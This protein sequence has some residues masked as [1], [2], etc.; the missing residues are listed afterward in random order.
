MPRLARLDAAGALHHVLVRGIE[1]GAIF[2]DRK[3]R[4]DFLLRLSRLVESESLQV[5]AWALMTNHVHLLIRTCRRSLSSSMRSLLSGYATAFNR[6]HRRAG[7]LFQNRFKSIVCE[8][9]PYFL[10]LIRYI[11]LNPVRA[12]IVSSLE[13]LERYPYSGHAAIVGS[14]SRPWQEVG[15]VLG[16]FGDRRRDAVRRYR[17]FVAEGLAKGESEDLEGGG[18]VRG[19]DGWMAVGSL[20][21]GRESFRA[22]ERV[23]G[24]SKFVDRLMSEVAAADARSS[25]VSLEELVA[26]VADVH[27]LSA[28]GLRSGSRNRRHVA[29]RAELSWIWTE[30]L[31]RSGRALAAELGVTAPAIYAGA[32]RHAATGVGAREEVAR[33]CRRRQGAGGPSHRVSDAAAAYGSKV[34]CGGGQAE[35]TI[36]ELRSLIRRVCRDREVTQAAVLGGGR[37]RS[38]V[39]ARGEICW[40]W[41]QRMGGSG[42]H[43]A[44]VLGLTAAAVYAASRR[45]ESRWSG[46]E[47]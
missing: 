38:V 15:E 28:D 18:L 11:H 26:I 40:E 46:V 13:G 24:S 14:L 35:R 6:R 39:E 10:E 31:G 21:R 22:D 29:A 37:G 23:L 44:R 4:E 8:E 30:Y 9:E 45:F 19:V 47:R 1:R 12:R 42:R 43:L 17:R 16:R 33:L 27:G 7:H 25:R 5:F 20:E 41:T 3:D 2:R 34:G 36:G 32:E